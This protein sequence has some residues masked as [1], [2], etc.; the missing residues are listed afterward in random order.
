MIYKI[1]ASKKLSRNFY[2]NEFD[3]FECAGITLKDLMSSIQA[4]ILSLSKDSDPITI[5]IEIGKSLS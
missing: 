4:N 2:K 3:I 5:T 1:L